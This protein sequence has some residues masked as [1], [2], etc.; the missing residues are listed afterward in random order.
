MR[1]AD[2]DFVLP[3]ELIAL[4]PA[5]VRDRAKLLVLNKDGAVEHRQFFNLS[6]YLQEGDMLLL[7]STKV[8]PARIAGRKQGGGAVDVLM[9]RPS[10]DEG[11]WE[12]LCRGRD[13]GD[14]TVF[15]GVAA[16]VWSESGGNGAPPKR[17]I[18]FS[19]IGPQDIMTLLW[20]HGCMPLPPYIKRDPGESDRERYQT[21]YAEK[22]GSIAAPTAGLHFTGELLDTLRDKGISV[23]TM[24]LHV[25]TGT[26][27]PV[28]AE[29]LEEHA[30]DSEYFEMDASLPGEIRRMRER[31]K[32]LVTVGTTATRAIEG[33]M[34]GR[35]EACSAHGNGI[36]SGHTDIFIYPGH[37]FRAVDGIV[38][39][40]HLP[41]STPLMLAAAFS[42]LQ[43]VLNA[44]ETAIST[45]YRFFSYGD[46]MLLL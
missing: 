31:G 9:V 11:V 26:F 41:G 22:Q 19:G 12:V 46:A 35:Y 1:T 44:Y 39:N 21:V 14:I 43:K 3:K 38:T 24:T 32:R 34:S 25:G 27:K 28:K 8:F 40:F 16:E 45:G 30:M 5:A 18:R 36:L 15:D 7:N 4:H 29:F 37:R 42:G 20:R 17:F 6:D 23:R 10:G 13:C 33:V 2:F